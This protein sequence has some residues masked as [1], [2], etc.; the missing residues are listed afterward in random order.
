MDFGYSDRLPEGTS[1]SE[2]PRLRRIGPRTL[3]ASTGTPFWVATISPRLAISDATRRTSLMWSRQASPSPLTIRA[4]SLGQID[5][6][7]RL[8]RS[9]RMVAEILSSKALDSGASHQGWP[10]SPSAI[11]AS[12]T[13]ARAPSSWALTARRAAISSSTSSWRSFGGMEGSLAL[14]FLPLMMRWCPS[15]V[16]SGV[17]SFVTIRLSPAGSCVFALASSTHRECL[18]DTD[19]APGLT[20]KNQRAKMVRCA[21]IRTPGLRL[22]AGRPRDLPKFP[23]V[24]VEGG[25]PRS[26]EGQPSDLASVAA[27]R[28][29]GFARRDVTG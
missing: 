20:L 5:E 7:M 3:S 27:I 10:R 11:F 18:H 25:P 15:G 19:V 2:E 21:G 28:G 12:L 9:A 4:T 24:C 6:S 29:C 16:V 1:L 17:L 14:H 8:R 23:H 22:S 13:R 26:R